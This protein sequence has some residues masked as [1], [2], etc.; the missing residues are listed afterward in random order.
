MR[1]PYFYLFAL[2]FSTIASAQDATDPLYPVFDRSVGRDQLGF[3]N[4]I[5]HRNPY[6]SANKTFRYLRDDFSKGSVVYDGQPYADLDL[7]YDLLND[8]LITRAGG[9]NSIVAIELITKKTDRFTLDGKT[10]L[11]LQNVFPDIPKTFVG[12]YEE[13]TFGHGLTL[14]TKHR[15]TRIEVKDVEGAFSRF[16]PDEDFVL[17]YEKKWYAANSESSVIAV[18]PQFEEQIRKFYG[19]NSGARN[20]DPKQFMKDL[21]QHL[22]YLLP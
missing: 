10:F 9:A 12:Y 3:N 17:R 5:V 21:A 16:E 8:I 22:D 11:H 13:N 18:F 14:Y 15:K 6:R 7:K 2:F 1:S 4:G 19:I 20:A